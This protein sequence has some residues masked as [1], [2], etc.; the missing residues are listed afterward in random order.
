MITSDREPVTKKIWVSAL[1]FGT[2]LAVDPSS[3][4]FYLGQELESGTSAFST[5]DPCKTTAPRARVA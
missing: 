4:P 3:P 2:E 5:L 1:S